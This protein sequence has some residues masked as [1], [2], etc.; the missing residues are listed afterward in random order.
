[1][2]DTLVARLTNCGFPYIVV[3]DGDYGRRGEL[4]LKHCYEGMELD[5]H[6]LERTLPHVYHLWR[7][8]VHLET[9]LEERRV[10]F[11]YDGERV[12]RSFAD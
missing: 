9:V 7:R 5:V 1:V 12:R 6:H 2:R 10:V 8:P 4:Y 3:E 11:S